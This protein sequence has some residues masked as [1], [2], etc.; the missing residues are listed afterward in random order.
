MPG[1]FVAAAC[2]P[3]F[4][5]R[6]GSGLCEE[7]GPA[8]SFLLSFFHSADSSHASLLRDLSPTAAAVLPL[9]SS[10]RNGAPSLREEEWAGHAGEIK[11][12]ALGLSSPAPRVVRGSVYIISGWP[13]SKILEE[14]MSRGLKDREPPRSGCVRR[15]LCST[16][17][18]WFKPEF[19]EIHCSGFQT[20]TVTTGRRHDSAADFN[21]FKQKRSKNLQQGFRPPTHFLPFLHFG[22]D[23]SRPVTAAARERRRPIM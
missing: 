8:S 5:P 22:D 14:N 2:F 9:R 1:C 21:W 15:Q 3:D 16:V 10:Q 13:A 18:S 20:H 23:A 4:R 11:T 17:Q 12:P 6:P 19:L 7:S